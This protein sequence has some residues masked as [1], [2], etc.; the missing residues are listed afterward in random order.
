MKKILSLMIG[1]G[2]MISVSAA[3]NNL[4]NPMKAAETVQMNLNIVWTL[5]AGI[6]VF[7]MQAG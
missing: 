2:V 1:C 6:L 4:P 3:D 5:I 7:A